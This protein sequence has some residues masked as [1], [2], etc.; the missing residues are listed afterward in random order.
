MVQFG[1]MELSESLAKKYKHGNIVTLKRG[2]VLLRAKCAFPSDHGFVLYL[3]SDTPISVETSHGTLDDI[4][5][6]IEI[7]IRVGE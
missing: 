5:G 3:G 4:G 2:S 7:P 6:T 1:D